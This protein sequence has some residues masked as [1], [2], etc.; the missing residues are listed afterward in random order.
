MS[1][2]TQLFVCIGLVIYVVSNEVKRDDEYIE[3]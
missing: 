1:H 2:L 3:S